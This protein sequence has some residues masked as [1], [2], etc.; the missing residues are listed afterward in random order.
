MIDTENRPRCRLYLITPSDVY[1]DKFPHFANSLKSVL[2]AGDVACVQLR[3]KNIEDEII[4]ETAERLR[5]ICHDHDVALIMNDRADLAAKSDCDGVHIGQNDT[6]YGEARKLLGDDAIIGVT[7][8]ASTHL[9]ME[10]GEVGADYVAFGAF[11]HSTTKQSRFSAKPDL[12]AQWQETMLVPCVA[13]GGITVKNC[14]PIIEAG[15]DFI[16]VSAGVWDHSGG[17]ISG[18]KAFNN[19]FESIATE[20]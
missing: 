11:F 14:R 1:G 18:V 2:D 5:L 20:L 10:A 3:L 15:A 13:I 8:H 17:P 7:C 9:A 4:I 19:I 6:P 12:L 16:A